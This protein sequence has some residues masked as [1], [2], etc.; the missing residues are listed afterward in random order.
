VIV[1]FHACYARPDIDDNAGPLV[2]QN[3]R[4]EPFG[5]SRSTSVIWS[6][7]PFSNAT[8]ARVFMAVFLLVDKPVISK[9]AAARCDGS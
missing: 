1:L 4:K 6:G 3:G 7:F 2:A 9:S 5:A 8:A